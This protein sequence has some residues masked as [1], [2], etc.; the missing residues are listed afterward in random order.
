MRQLLYVAQG[1]M[2]FRQLKHLTNIILNR[3]VII[4]IIIRDQK[5]HNI[6]MHNTRKLFRIVNKT[7]KN[8]KLKNSLTFIHNKL[9]SIVRSFKYLNLFFYTSSISQCEAVNGF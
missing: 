3:F 4:N 5:E 7:V 6:V 8:R 9:T 2:R 1:F